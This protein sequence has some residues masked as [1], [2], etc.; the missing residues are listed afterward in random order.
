MAVLSIENERSK[1]I[2]F[3]NIINMLISF[4]SRKVKLWNSGLGINKIYKQNNIVSFN[5]YTFQFFQ[6]I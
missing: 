3:K 2:E 4:K 5:T 6:I 1:A